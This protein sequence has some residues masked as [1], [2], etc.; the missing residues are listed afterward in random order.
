MVKYLSVHDSS[1]ALRYFL[2]QMATPHFD[3]P[4]VKFMIGL[5]TFVNVYI[6]CKGGLEL[7]TFT[8]TFSFS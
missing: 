3:T 6:S 4:L 5:I 1:F 7:D 8:S 2:M